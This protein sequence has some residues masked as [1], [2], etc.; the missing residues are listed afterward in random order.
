MPIKP[1]L[2]PGSKIF[3]VGE[4][5]GKEEEFLQIPFCGAA[6]QELQ[7]M[8]ADAGISYADCSVSSVFL[9]RPQDSKIENFC[10]KK[11]EAGYNYPPAYSQ[12]K[13]FKK[14]L[15]PNR[16][17][18]YAEI[19]QVSPN[20]VIALGNAAIWACLDKVGIGSL[21]GAVISS[22]HFRAKVL[23][24]YQPSAILR[25]WEQRPVTVIDFMKA[26]RESAYPEIR[27]EKVQIIMEPSLADLE[28]Y[29]NL[30][31]SA[32]ELAY[33]I[34]T[35]PSRGLITCVGF[36]FGDTAIVCPFVD[37][38][39]EGY[40]YWPSLH[41]ELSAWNFV[42]SMLSLPCPKIT[43]NGL[44]DI[45]W[46]WKKMGMCPAGTSEDTMLFHHSLF[47]EMEKGLDYLGSVYCEFPAWKTLRKRGDFNKRED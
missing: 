21:R 39:K 35:K 22:P 17:R 20:I 16:E 1:I 33:D 46:L 24:A 28:A 36:G 27:Y 2:K 19:E 45:S 8:L 15:L 38:R 34:E 30:A 41:E 7:K 42:R 29:Y 18:L 43:Q 25:N 6:G 5:P 47:P 37:T 12:G 32:S 14:E 44:Y 31:K 40:N 23:P 11:A 13:Y 26:R 3:I 9:E 10:V 4:A